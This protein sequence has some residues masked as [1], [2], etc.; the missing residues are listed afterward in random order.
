MKPIIKK[1]KLD[2]FDLKSWR[3][4]A[5]VTFISKLIER[6]TIQQ[7]N[8]LTTEHHHLPS[9]QLLLLLLLLLLLHLVMNPAKCYTNYK[10]HAPSEKT[11]SE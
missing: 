2:P 7:F 9:N 3:L 10:V 5:N 11:N 8:E 1:P 4:I 6:L